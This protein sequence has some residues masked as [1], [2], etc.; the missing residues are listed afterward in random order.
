MI[1]V[2]IVINLNQCIKN[3]QV[4]NYSREFFFF[5]N[6]RKKDKFTKKKKY[7]ALAI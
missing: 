5:D 2:I 7:N 6:N 1:D 4:G 3:V